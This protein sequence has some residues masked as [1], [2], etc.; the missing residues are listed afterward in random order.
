MSETQTNEISVRVLLHPGGGGGQPWPCPAGVNIQLKRTGTGAR[1]AQP[2]NLTTAAGGVTPP[3]SLVHGTYQV[4]ITDSRFA[5]WETASPAVSSD[6]AELIVAA[7]VVTRNV[8]ATGQRKEA[9]EATALEVTALQ[10]AEAAAETEAELRDVSFVPEAGY[11]AVVVRLATSDG[12]PVS[13]GTAR[14]TAAASFDETFTAFPDGSIYAVSP[15]GPV[16][17]TLVSVDL[18]EHRYCPQAFEFPYTVTAASEVKSL[19]LLYW[20]AIQIVAKPTIA[21]PN[22]SLCPLYGT[23]V[24]VLYQLNEQSGGVSRKRVLELGAA[25]DEVLFEYSFPGTYTITMTPPVEFHGLPIQPLPAL[26]PVPLPA[27][28]CYQV[29]AA[30]KVVPTVSAAIVVTTP[31]NQPL[32]A[33]IAFEIYNGNTLIPV[34]VDSTVLKT[35]ATFPSGIPVKIRLANGSNPAIGGVPLQMSIPDQ[36]LNPGPNTV[37]LEYEHSLT[38]EAMDE[39][40]RPVSGATID[41]YYGPTETYRAPLPWARMVAGCCRWPGAARTTWASTWWGVNLSAGKPYR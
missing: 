3:V 10:E 18:G 14:I 9:V 19:D 30:F 20:P 34:S 4:R 11:R 32:D 33:N 17:V 37:E 27:G 23:S 13:T 38:I 24:T 7:V 12:Q 1:S 15:M 22:G 41:V 21:D 16:I 8:A 29:P 25:N 35:P 36:S 5:L 28:S 40:D 39:Q 31:D 2:V 6:P 26:P